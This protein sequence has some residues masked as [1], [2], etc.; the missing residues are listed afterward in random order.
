MWKPREASWHVDQRPL[1]AHR[2]SVEDLQWSPT[3]K[4]VLASCSV[5]KSIR[6][7]D[8]RKYGAKANVI[9]VENAHTSDINVISW[10]RKE[11]FIV[12]GGDDGFVHVWDLRNLKVIKEYFYFKILR[13]IIDTRSVQ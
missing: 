7:W 4:E 9:T 11:P 1:N 10:N 6:I 5:D 3:E 2:E 8:T 13:K 12:S